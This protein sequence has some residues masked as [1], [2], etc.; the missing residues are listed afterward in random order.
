MNMHS[1]S[2]ARQTVGFLDNAGARLSQSLRRLSSGVKVEKG[3]D[4]G[5]LAVSSKLES[6]VTRSLTIAEN[7][8]NGVS[9]LEAQDAAQSKLGDIL[10]RISELRVRLDDP[11]TNQGDAN[12]Y[13]REFHDLKDE[14]RAIS[15]KKFN[16]V[17]LFADGIHDESKLVID[18]SS[19]GRSS[20]G[21]ITR[22]LFFNTIQQT[23]SSGGPAGAN[24]TVNGSSGSFAGNVT[25]FRGTA[26]DQTVNGARG[27]T[28]D[29]IVNGAG[30]STPDQSV[31]G[32]GGSTP[33]QT[34]K[35]T[36]GTTP[37]QT[38]N[39][40]GG[41]TPAQTVNG[42]QGTT[43]SQIVSLASGGRA[44]NQVITALQGTTPVTTVSMASGTVTGLTITAALSGI[45]PAPLTLN[46]TQG[47]APQALWQ[48]SFNDVS[49]GFH[50]LS[51]VFDTNGDI[52]VGTHAD[53]ELYRLDPNDGRVLTTYNMGSGKNWSW[54]SAVTN[55]TVYA[56]N[57]D[58]RELFA[59]DK[60]SGAEK[61][62]AALN[63]DTEC[64]PYVHSNGNVYIATNSSGPWWNPVAG[65]VYG[66]APDGT[67]LANFPIDVDGQFRGGFAEAADGTLYLTSRSNIFFNPNLMSI[68]PTSGAI[69]WSKTNLQA[70][71]MFR[72][73][74]VAPDNSVVI[75]DISGVTRSYNADGSDNWTYNHGGAAIRGT[76]TIDPA[77][78]TVYV[79]SANG[80]VALQDNG[81]A[82]PNV[83]WNFATGFDANTITP[84]FD[85]N[86]NL[87][88]IANVNTGEIIALDAT[89]GG[90]PAG[91]EVWR[92]AT[93]SGVI[94]SPALDANGNVYIGN[95]DGDFFAISVYDYINNPAVT[96]GIGSGYD[97]TEPPPS[98]VIEGSDRGNLAATAT[99]NP[100]GTLK[101]NFTGKA[102]GIGNLTVTVKNI[103]GTP[104][105]VDPVTGGYNSTEPAPLARVL[106]EGIADKPASLRTGLVALI[107]GNGAPPAGGGTITDSSGS[108]NDGTV[109]SG[110]EP[111]HETTER[112]SGTGAYEF[113]GANDKILLGDLNGQIGGQDKLTISAWV[114]RDDTGDD[115]IVCKSSGTNVANHAFSMGVVNAGGTESR[116]RMRVGTTTMVATS[117]DGALTFPTQEWTH[118]AMTYDGTELRS[119]V[120]GELDPNVFS[121]NGNL[122]S[123]ADPVTIG[124]VNNAQNRH[125]NGKLDD[126]GLWNRALTANEIESLAGPGNLTATTSINP[127]GTL[128]VTPAGNPA[129]D[130]TFA[131]E[132]DPGVP[133]LSGVIVGSGYDGATPEAA[134]AVTFT[135]GPVGTVAGTATVRPDGQ[136]NVAFTGTPSGPGQ[137]TMTVAD[138]VIRAPGNLTGIADPANLYDPAEAAPTVVITGA[139]K[140]TLA[141]T[142]TIQADGNVNVAFS[143]SP[144]GPGAITVALADGVE[145][146]PANLSGIGSGYDPAESAPTV[147]ITGTNKG[148]LAGTATINPN[149]TLNVAFS[150]LPTANT[151]AVE[152]WNTGTLTNQDADT[153]PV[154]DSSGVTYFVASTNAG[155]TVNA[156]NSS[157]GSTVWSIPLGT[158]AVC[159]P[160]LSA[161]ESTL[162]VGHNNGL[163]ALNTADGSQRW[164]YASGT[165]NTSQPALS[166][167]GQTVY[168][169]SADD[170]L[171]AVNTADGSGKWR[172]DTGAN[173]ESAAVVDAAG[174]VYV[175]STNRNVYKLQ[176]NGGSATQL[177][178]NNSSFSGGGTFG[179]NNG[180]SP[181]LS[182]DGSV[183]YL[184]DGDGNV[185]AL[186]TATGTDNWGGTV[187]VTGRIRGHFAVGP[188]D[189]V[190]FTSTD[191]RVFAFKDNGAS[192]T[193][194]GNFQ[195][196]SN[197]TRQSP[198]VSA[199]NEVF[200]VSGG[201]VAYSLDGTNPA[202]W[203]D[204]TNLSG[205]NWEH[206]MGSTSQSTPALD[207][208]G[209]VAFIGSN[210]NR[211]YAFTAE[212]TDPAVDPGNVTIS[213]A[214]GTIR[215]PANLT[216]IGSG[217][218][219][220]ETAPTVTVTGANKGTLA[221]TST[222]NVDGTLNVTFTGA[223]TD[224]NNVTVSVAN[225]VA[226]V[227]NLTGIG[228]GYTLGDPV[229]AVTITGAN[230]GTLAGTSTIN[231]DGTLDVA[232]TGSPTDMNNVSVQVADGL[233]RVGNL[234]NI[235]SGYDPTEAAPA[236]TIV[237]ANKGTLT[238]T[239]TI[240]PDGT[241]NV[242]FTGNPTDF[243][244]LTVQI[245]DGASQ[246]GN[247]A[248]IGS[249][250]DPA[251]AAPAVTIVGANKG[252]LAGTASIN[253]DGTLNVNFTGNPTD[254]ANLTVQIADGLVGLAN[255]ANIGS[256][257]DPAEA[258]PAVTI[259][260]ANKGTLAGTSSVNPDGTL[261]VNFAGNPTDTA[262]LT[263]QVADGAIGVGNLTNIGSGYDPAEPAPA[264]TI[265]GANKGTL[266]GTASVNP[267]GTLNVNFAGNPTD[268]AN[269]TVQLADG[270]A[271]VNNLAGVGGGYDPAEA[272]PAV[273]IS[274]ATQGT[275]AGTSSIN[276][277]GTLNVNFTGNP[278]DVTVLGV[279]A[280]NG[281]IQPPANL[282]GL[283]SNHDPASP[284]AVTI[285]GAD[286]GTLAATA[287]V[288]PNGSVN[289]N[290]TGN[291][292]GTG[293]LGVQVAGS[294]GGPPTNAISSKYLL[295]M[296]G[297]LWDFTVEEFTNMVQIVSDA[298][299]QNGAEQASLNTFWNLLSSNVTE[300]ERAAGRITDADFARE[301]TQLGKAHILSRS[302]ASMLVN[303]NR[304]NSEALLTIQRLQNLL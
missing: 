23:S 149:G 67:Q 213:V 170:D 53:D 196:A 233:A 198:T 258:A 164:N 86:R 108:G 273:T 51:P 225:G 50:R 188:N 302:A 231:A 144:S 297:D 284:P 223:P 65:R 107:D 248:N 180:S 157:D 199:T 148:T 217:Y 98:V 131:V 224:T 211:L 281:I 22:N 218:D 99:V 114:Y 75:N 76:P 304:S 154:I 24:R 266:T 290:F 207:P 260:G 291:P 276:P 20:S 274:G 11:A 6:A 56:A 215:K 87:L 252:T 61:W 178:V 163:R 293:P 249:G 130:G 7:V 58:G 159:N 268:T 59:F 101:L 28:P 13:N 46:A 158:S 301:M 253:A 162:F 93:G 57:G 220:T 277:D 289:V 88:Y 204:S 83:L 105:P 44:S 221:G 270:L 78:G 4:A 123:T 68:N 3:G 183:L 137:L 206:A 142:A 110:Q 77:T 197:F 147:T 278:T 25:P 255:L 303:Q 167:D 200:F 240:N 192:A 155:T 106:A 91:S 250:Y 72:A 179:F 10:T 229:P 126:V 239:S 283:G 264:V 9:F 14:I 241:L 201:G 247:L 38:V 251:E 292:S 259:V 40:A 175:A 43:T 174:N 267:D 300:L 12:N 8:Q 129:T 103:T 15:K 184:G 113:D 109:A 269:L 172:F 153:K 96:D 189:N 92:Y 119:Y 47:N 66:Y 209:K 125:F 89:G 298:R 121:V 203:G 173:I 140:G 70:G 127:D 62:S 214:D 205:V 134:P 191:S 186:D 230:K 216:S 60:V 74:A 5:G 285:T 17:S 265:V 238:G 1:F 152:L 168:F 219:P 102:S 263:V 171:H 177:W 21:E 202:S 208:T 115:R 94:A 212:P 156:V 128:R 2:E 39:G 81:T 63:A 187:Q 54:K 222:I 85:P 244:D 32:T 90:N 49:Q 18:T 151:S 45:P 35:G 117:M 169:G 135:G 295:D 146:P 112:R 288:N 52:I 228:S 286:Q 29:Q 294:S 227:P 104:P 176:D 195:V 261:N 235:G 141:G 69:N 41:T 27:T 19:D 296:D 280:A 257:Y 34:V 136:L 79:A 262:N 36:G 16:G 26:P 160:T 210:D 254:F 116:I 95:T 100:D 236:V 73:P 48:G 242:S 226:G 271:R 166:N 246:V 165:V 232:F 182:N 118:L 185:A 299:A 287:S 84:A 133:G 245:A 42:L 143:G 111:A 138:G 124:N 30:G 80:I 237:G 150:G 275:L 243:A 122:L 64:P 82:T 181:A 55:D 33:N 145:R 139:N 256:G 71:R 37:N 279:Q 193:E 234:A 132:V 272:A 282:T 190:Y 194:L 31:N 97:P 120:N 161:D